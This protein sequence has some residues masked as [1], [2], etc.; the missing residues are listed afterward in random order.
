M[1][2]RL[3]ALILIA[4]LCMT[5]MVGCAGSGKANETNAPGSTAPEVSQEPG[6]SGGETIKVGLLAPLTGDVAHYGTAVKNA[7]TMYLD[8]FNAEGG[9][10][11]TPIEL[12]VYDEKGNATEAVNAYNKLVNDDE[13]VA[14]IG[15]VTTTPTFAVAQASVADNM[16][17]LTPTATH[18]DVT[19][20]GKNIFRACFQDPFQ[21][22]TMAKLAYNDLGAKTA[23][24]IYNSSDA[25]ST[26]LK[27]SFT[28]TSKEIGL[29][30]VAT[31]AYG[32]DDVAFQS[33]LTNIGGANPDVIFIPDYYNQCYMIATQAKDMGITAKL[34]GVDGTDGVLAIE[35]ADTSV[36][37]G[38]YFSNHY[39]VG[40]TSDMIKN[41]V[42]EYNE[43]YGD[44]PNALAA[45][46]YD[47]AMIMFAAIK[48]VADSGITIDNS[49]E[50]RQAIIDAIKT[51]DMTTVTGHLTFDEN[52]NPVKELTIIKIVYSDGKASYE[53]YKKY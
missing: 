40:D 22:S 10:N 25:Y 24:I 3:L 51:T 6:N 12:I 4:A 52:N 49:D 45:L 20:Y 1:K 8:K 30:I 29:E 34:L 46:G 17:L 37:D 19:S 42:G 15:D 44:D 14:I 2:R 35:G 18:P 38:I 33:Q 9:V 50:C 21:G 41:F 26:G 13:V 32:A 27:D 43:R 11:G 53:F 31:E 48:S 47:A 5:G 7:V 28:E 16:P 36:L 23:A 39:F